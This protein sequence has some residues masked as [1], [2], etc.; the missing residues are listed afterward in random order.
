MALDGW[1]QSK[2]E[3][4]GT[5]WRRYSFSRQRRN[6]DDNDNPTID[7]IYRYYRALGIYFKNTVLFYIKVS[8]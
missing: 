2:N 6:A 1:V 8:L 3:M 5:T 7:S 4:I